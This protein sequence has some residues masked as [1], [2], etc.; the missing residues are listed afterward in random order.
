[1]GG[2][3]RVRFWAESSHRTR[4]RIETAGTA[5]SASPTRACCGGVEAAQGMSENAVSESRV[6]R[7]MAH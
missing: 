2:R 4:T 1:M 7:R 6:E 5:R 3:H